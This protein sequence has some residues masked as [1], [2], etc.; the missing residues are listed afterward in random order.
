[1]PEP[2]PIYRT[3]EPPVSVEGMTTGGLQRAP[4]TLAQRHV[5]PQETAKLRIHAPE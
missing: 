1:M 2:K 5:V 3:T 4:S